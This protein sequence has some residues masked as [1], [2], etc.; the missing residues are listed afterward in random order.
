MLSSDLIIVLGLLFCVLTYVMAVTRAVR[1]SIEM[2]KWK[3][4]ADKG[5]EGPEEPVSTGS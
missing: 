2:A 5:A 4:E 1:R 3:T